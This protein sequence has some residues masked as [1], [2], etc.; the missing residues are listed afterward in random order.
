[1]TR[2]RM[3]VIL[4][5]AI[6][7]VPFGLER[8]NSNAASTTAP[9]VPL[10]AFDFAG[11]TAYPARA[12]VR[13][14]DVDIP[15]GASEVHVPIMLDRPTPNTIAA[16]VLTRNGSGPRYGYEGKHF[17]KVDTWVFFRPG[18]PLVQTVRVP[19]RNLDEGRHFDLIFPAG[20]VGGKNAGGRG[21]ITV[22]AKAA[23]SV[24][25]TSGFRPPRQFSPTSALA[26]RFDPG[27]ADW[28]DGGTNTAWSTRLPH[29]RTQPGNA[30]TGLY[31]D[32]EKHRSP[33]RPI[34][35]EN[36]ELVLRS[37]QLPTGIRY[38]GK[39]WHHGAAVLTGEKM[40][41][42]QIRYG[43]YEWEALMPNR[44][45]G[46]PALW[47][48]AS[49]GWPPEIDVY[50]GFGYSPDFDFSRDI[51]SNLHG[52]SGGNRTFVVPVRL[53]AKSAYRIDRFD[54]SYHRFAVDIAPDFITWFVDGKEVFQAMNPFRGT[55]WFP[56]MTVAV[57]CDGDYSGGS[58]EMRVRSFSVWSVE[59]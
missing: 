55:S 13:I 26:Y 28:T 44:R 21:K 52:G 40:P 41:A 4:A 50:E 9:S 35:I 39:V 11:G 58:A 3:V 54:T 33:L 10:A 49:G 5:I 2:S 56:L 20:V 37:Q 17:T 42:T 32:P 47:L 12:E 36:G 8:L 59:E 19:L 46:W 51:S 1:M 57:K 34:A 45:G 14:G 24:A 25:R 29:G 23:P 16:R 7:L 31:L 43:Q 15:P 6:V 53:D 38:D 18:D 30:E 27:A 48:L 22:V